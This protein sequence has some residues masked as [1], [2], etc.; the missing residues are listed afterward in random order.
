MFPKQYLINNGED[1]TCS[2]EKRKVSILDKSSSIH[3]HHLLPLLNFWFQFPRLS[4]FLI[5]AD[6]VRQGEHHSSK[7]ILSPSYSTQLYP[8]PRSVGASFHYSMEQPDSPSWIFGIVQAPNKFQCIEDWITLCKWS[9]FSLVTG[10]YI[11]SD[12]DPNQNKLG[13]YDSS[14]IELANNSPVILKYKLPP[15]KFSTKTAP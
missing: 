5:H 14:I 7:P 4:S 6:L 12:F 2:R 10:W 13:R 11:E 8:I 3:S 9:W 1:I 15:S